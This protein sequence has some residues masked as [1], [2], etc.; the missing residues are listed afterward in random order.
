MEDPKHAPRPSIDVN[1]DEP[2]RVRPREEW[3]REDEARVR[4]LR[5]DL[6]RRQF[7]VTL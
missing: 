7:R 1:P 5:R 3:M 2:P 6:L 4:E